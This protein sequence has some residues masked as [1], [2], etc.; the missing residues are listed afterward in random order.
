MKA[1]AY[2]E[3]GRLEVLEVEEPE[4]EPG[5]VL[6]EVAAC[7]VCGSDLESLRHGSNVTPGQVMGHEIGGRLLD[8]GGVEGLSEG[9]VVAVRPLLACGECASCLRGSTQLCERSLQQGLGYGLPGGFA[10]RLRVPKAARGMNVFVLPADLDPTLAALV[11]PL[12]VSLR[13]V[14]QAEV[15]PGD[16]VLVLGLGQIGLGALVLARLQGA[17]HVIGVDPSPLR[18]DAAAAA[19]ATMTVDPLAT[20]VEQVVRDLTGP[21]PYGL[22]AAADCAIECSGVPSSFTAAVKSLRPEGRLSLIAHSRE[23]FAVKSGRIV[24]KELRVQGSF[25]YRDEMREVADLIGAGRLDLTPFVSH[26]LSLS[27]I[28][29]AFAVQGNAAESLKVLMQP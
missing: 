7:G 14:K 3:P 24:E 17:E 23:P 21:G 29:A 27:D 11:E 12:A 20:K 1:A 10:Q 25:A 19:G 9:D 13:G 22:G 18:R 26:R 8:A 5:D 16:V 15:G 6:L 2:V 4:L 28:E